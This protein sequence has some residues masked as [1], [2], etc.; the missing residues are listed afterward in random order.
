[1]DS[2]LDDNF[3]DSC[4]PTGDPDMPGHSG[5]GGSD[6]NASEPPHGPLDT[7]R[8]ADGEHEHGNNN[9]P[10]QLLPELQTTQD[11]IEALRIAVLKDSGMDHKDINCLQRPELVDSLDDPSPLLHSL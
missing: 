2:D 4:G 1:M 9:T 10:C 5:A 7:D 6:P 3:G 8:T 11:Y